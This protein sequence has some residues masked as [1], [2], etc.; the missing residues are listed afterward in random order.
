MTFFMKA[1]ETW[2]QQGV[3]GRGHL[4]FKNS[5]WLGDFKEITPALYGLASR[6]RLK[7]FF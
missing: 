3:V 6:I 7:Y 1:G 2:L 4:K 5:L